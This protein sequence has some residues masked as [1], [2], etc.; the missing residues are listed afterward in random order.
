MTRVFVLSSFSLGLVYGST[1]DIFAGKTGCTELV[2]PTF[3]YYEG[4]G[5]KSTAEAK[6]LNQYNSA[7]LLPKTLTYSSK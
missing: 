4:G 1:I 7:E 6:W 5:P 3:C 2:G